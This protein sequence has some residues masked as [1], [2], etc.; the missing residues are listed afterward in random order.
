MTG[1]DL[2]FEGLC[3]KFCEAMKVILRLLGLG[4]HDKVQNI[5]QWSQEARFMAEL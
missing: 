2:H 3:E 1:Y 4:T 5:T